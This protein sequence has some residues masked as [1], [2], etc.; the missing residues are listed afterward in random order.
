MIWLQ[1]E[2]EY[3]YNLVL[4]SLSPISNQFGFV[5][6]EEALLLKEITEPILSSGQIQSPLI[7]K[8]C[9]S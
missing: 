1:T 7:V 5:G 9:H 3:F 2:T 8:F 6:A 4:S